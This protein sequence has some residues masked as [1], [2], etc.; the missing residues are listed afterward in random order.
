MKLTGFQVQMFK[1]VLDSGWIEVEPLTVL[2]GKN[3][4]GKTSILK[5]L[6]K[7][8]PFTPD[9]Y[10]I[11]REWPRAHRDSRSEDQIVCTAEFELSEHEIDELRQIAGEAVELTKVKVTKD[12]A[13][14]VEVLFAEGLF[15]DKLHPNDIDAICAKLPS[16]PQP[17]KVEFAEAAKECCE[18]VI[19][20]AKEGRYSDLAGCGES[21]QKTLEGLR[22]PGDQN[23]Q[24]Q[25][26]QTFISQYV[27]A[28][29]EMQKLIKE[30]PSIQ[31]RAH[32]YVVSN[33]PTFVYMD[34]YR[35]FVG[36]ALLDQVK[37]RCDQKKATETD[38]TLLTILS[39]AA[40]DL[41]ELVK[42]G[43][44]ANREERQLDL[45]DGAATLT[46][47]IAS[48]WKSLRYQVQFT[49]DGQEFI[50]W[51]RD[52]K[53]KGL[54]KLEERSRGF[55][56]FFSFDLMLMHET[57]GTMKDCVI[58]L[59]E[60]GLHLHPKA[61]RDLLE[62]LA[63]YASGNT[64]I[65][66]THLPFMID[67]QEPQRI[68]VISE[69]D[70]GTTVG[71]DLTLSQPDA[72]LTLQAALGM[73]G[74][75]SFLVAPKNL[76]VE[77]AHDY[78]IL[79]RLASLLERN[80]DAGLPDDV[81]ITAAG[82]AQEVTYI[83][84]LMI[85]QELAVVALYDSDAEGRTAKDR[86]VKNWLTKYK[87]R[88]AVALDLAEAAGEKQHTFAIEDLF[89]EDFYLK[90]VK[91]TYARQLAAAQ[92]DKLSLPDG[93][94]LVGRCTAALDAAGITFN[95][96]SVAKRLCAAIG[97]MSSLNELPEET[98]TRVKSIFAAI[99]RALPEGE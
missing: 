21:H 47:K 43:Q 69:T 15:P 82:G 38:K 2:V 98:A 5:A 72:K 75:S 66:T 67:L 24:H 51:V 34:E 29:K 36:T 74:S 13:G 31:T 87:D 30:T 4:S 94:S 93:G 65:Y 63:D 33:L 25:H 78:W 62:R 17:T 50:T 92:V 73:S 85:G 37:Q 81:M 11:P 28:M 86:L 42:S 80:G 39:L 77:G 44:A 83:A 68:R 96:G 48:H 61:Q 79:T 20:L 9:P 56:W 52:P 10:S 6:H 40:L 84:T 60:P 18:E 32:D 45:A 70:H 58:L 54:V 90:F 64:L 26:E 16:V 76:V 91:E 53:D 59:D 3:E 41:D 19:R 57:K 88:Q 97:K 1:C 71:E 99:N 95:K 22:S 46:D 89:T 14:R 23:P 27:A 12:Y 49:A 7:L 35:S 8:N 55:Q